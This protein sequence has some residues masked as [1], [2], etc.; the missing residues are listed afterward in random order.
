MARSVLYLNSCGG[1]VIYQQL[2]KMLAFLLCLYTPA[3]EAEAVEEFLAYITDMKE[4]MIGNE[5]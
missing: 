3:E 2:T 5:E 1:N 4:P